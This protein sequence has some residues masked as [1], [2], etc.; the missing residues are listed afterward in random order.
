[1]RQKDPIFYFIHFFKMKSKFLKDRTFMAGKI[2]PLKTVKTIPS[3]NN[4][5]RGIV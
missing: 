3:K 4:A 5:F 1:M 2:T